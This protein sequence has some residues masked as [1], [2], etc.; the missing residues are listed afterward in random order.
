MVLAPYRSVS[1]SIPAAGALTYPEHYWLS[2]RTLY[3]ATAPR[4]PRGSGLRPQSGLQVT[5]VNSCCS[6]GPVL[7]P[8]YHEWRAIRSKKV[9]S[10]RIV[11]LLHLSLPPAWV[12]P[13][14]VGAFPLCLP[15]SLQDRGCWA[16]ANPGNHS[17][18]PLRPHTALCDPNG[19]SP[20]IGTDHPITGF[21]IPPRQ[22]PGDAPR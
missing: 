2:R 17:G 13:N 22:P 10:G 1:V 8:F 19:Y 15:A 6:D 5:T 12:V 16:W 4:I 9:D 7:P 11:A 18:L 3:P 14:S 20:E 21:A